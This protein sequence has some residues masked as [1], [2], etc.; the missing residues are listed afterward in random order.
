MFT[1]AELDGLAEPVRRH[2]KRAIAP[3]T[4]LTRCARITMHGSIKL[5]RWL[6]FHARQVL[7][8]VDGF[9]WAA[10][11]A[12]VI[13]GSDHYLDGVGGMDWKLAGLVT[14]AHEAGPRCPVAR[15]DEEVPRRSGSPPPCCHASA[16]A[17][18]PTTTR[19]SPPTTGSATRRSTFATRSGATDASVLSPSTDGAT[20]PR[21]GAGRG[22]PSA[23]KSPPNAPS[24]GLSIPSGALSV[25]RLGWHF[26]TDRW[27]AGEFLR[28]KITMLQPRDSAPCE[29]RRTSPLS[30]KLACE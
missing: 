11:V 17:G 10:R 28:Y 20:P 19:T 8:P 25:G 12:G 15:P 9:F 2:L 1:G 3:D 5:G 14:V 13:A 7:N 22:T 18:R 24:P 30:G 16:C 27:P 23:V 6:P 29:R 21:L 26:G 4:P